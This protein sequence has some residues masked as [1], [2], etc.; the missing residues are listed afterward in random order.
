MIKLL[1]SITE[2]QCMLHDDKNY[3]RRAQRQ[4]AS[5]INSAAGLCLQEDNTIR[6]DDKM[7]RPLWYKGRRYMVYVGDVTEHIMYGD[8]VPMCT[9]RVFTLIER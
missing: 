3:S 6:V 2:L 5:I 8:D 1:Q 7:F 4:M 9:K